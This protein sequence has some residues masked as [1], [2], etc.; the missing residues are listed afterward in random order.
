MEDV[1]LSGCI[2]KWG[3]IRPTSY[4][5]FETE[6]ITSEAALN[7]TMVGYRT[8]VNTPFLVP[9]CTFVVHSLSPDQVPIARENV[10]RAKELVTSELRCWPNA[11]KVLYDAEI[12]LAPLDASQFAGDPMWDVY[13]ERELQ[14]LVSCSRFHD[15]EGISRG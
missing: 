2:W 6:V 8:E 15:P 1:A 3:N 11:S 14:A 7:Y 12:T 5:D 13:D 9:P 4:L 10:Q